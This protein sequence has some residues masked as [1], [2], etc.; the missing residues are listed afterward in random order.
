ML[1]V[2][3]L[4]PG[5]LL[6]LKDLCAHPATAPFALTGGTALA[7]RFGHRLS[8]DLDFF[9]PE[10]FNSKAIADQ[11]EAD[12][13]GTGVRVNPTGM[14]LM[15]RGV[16]V[17]LVRYRYALLDSFEVI[18]GVRLFGLRDNVAMKLSALTNRGAKKDFFDAHELIR[19]FGLEQL[20][21][22]YRQKY[23]VHDATM[24]L[25]SLAYFADAEEDM[26]PESL[27]GTTWDAVKTTISLAVRACL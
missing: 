8:V 4:P 17:D 15:L 26:D 20:L 1:H 21:E 25:R 18:D 11:I 2:S 13:E 6:L 3:S 12:F 23:V 14:N 16:K 5:T 27:D 19:R 7:L 24:V 9:T 22:W 10:T